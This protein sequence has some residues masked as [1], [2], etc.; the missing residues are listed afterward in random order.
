MLLAKC[1]YE[2]SKCAS[3]VIFVVNKL[4]FYYS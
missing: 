4:Y 2:K 3:Q 1:C